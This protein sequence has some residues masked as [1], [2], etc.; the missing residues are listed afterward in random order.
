VKSVNNVHLLTPKIR[1]L[2]MKFFAI[3]GYFSK[4]LFR[5]GK[6]PKGG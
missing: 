4:F 3:V 1:R 6:I 2:G 5:F